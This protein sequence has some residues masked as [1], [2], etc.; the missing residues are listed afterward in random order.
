MAGVD[1]PRDDV[2]PLVPRLRKAVEEH[3][4]AARRQP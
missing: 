2:A 1:E 4:Y 3:D